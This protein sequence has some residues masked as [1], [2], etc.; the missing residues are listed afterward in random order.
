M[1]SVG[2]QRAT[3][4]CELYSAAAIMKITCTVQLSMSSHFFFPCNTKFYFFSRVHH[5]M[6]HNGSPTFRAHFAQFH[7][8]SI[9]SC[10]FV[11]LQ[12]F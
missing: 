6:L 10:A 8:H 4:S 7:V 5:I 11:P 2:Q 12:R 3:L 9:L 1:L